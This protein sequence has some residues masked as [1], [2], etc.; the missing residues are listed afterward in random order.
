M[1]EAMRRVVPK[2]LALGSPDALRSK[3]RPA[4]R[5]NAKPLERLQRMRL[6]QPV[7]PKLKVSHWL[8]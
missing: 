3:P 2:S 1:V 4:F 7:L 6:G 5:P 8:S